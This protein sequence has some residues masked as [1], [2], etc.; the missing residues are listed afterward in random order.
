MAHSIFVED[1]VWTTPRYVYLLGYIDPRLDLQEQ[2]YP[3]ISHCC[4]V[5][6]CENETVHPLYLAY[7]NV[8]FFCLALLG[9]FDLLLPLSWCKLMAHD[10]FFT[11]LLLLETFFFSLLIYRNGALMFIFL[12]ARVLFDNQKLEVRTLIQGQSI[13]LIYIYINTYIHTHI[14]Y[15]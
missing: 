6:G 9:A 5:K 12:E 1:C 4:F 10:F 13:T 14:Y 3:L 8:R 7:A 2:E 15:T 11:F